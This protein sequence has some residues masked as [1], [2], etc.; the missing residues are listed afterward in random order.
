M[1]FRGNNNMD[2]QEFV[3]KRDT[4]GGRKAVESE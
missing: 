4:M 2:S 3:T 1:E